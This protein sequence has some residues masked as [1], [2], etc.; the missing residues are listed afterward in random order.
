MGQ[1][2][3]SAIKGEERV[4][5]NNIF[6]IKERTIEFFE[7]NNIFEE[8]I[9]LLKNHKVTTLF[10]YFKNSKMASDFL[11][12]HISDIEYVNDD[13]LKEL[14]FNEL[15][16]YFNGKGSANIVLNEKN[17]YTSF[18]IVIDEKRLYLEKADVLVIPILGV[19]SGFIL[20]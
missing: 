16:A 2:V 18:F 11:L 10:L 8:I 7:E 15:K 6:P 17:D 14:S 5:K 19:A 4:M 3:Q 20:K 12:K 13:I 1:V 9:D